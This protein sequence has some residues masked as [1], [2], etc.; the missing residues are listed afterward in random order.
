MNNCPFLIN[1]QS[2]KFIFTTLHFKNNEKFKKNGNSKILVWMMTFVLKNY[3][4]KWED[5]YE[6]YRL[7]TN[8]K[9]L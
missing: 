4:I 8:S 2:V 6:R 9:I 3:I 7:Q 5:I 1:L